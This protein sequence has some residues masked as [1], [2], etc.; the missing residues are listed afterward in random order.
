MKKIKL[1][2]MEEIPGDVQIAD[3]GVIKYMMDFGY[4]A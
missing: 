2:I 1:F 4:T 3:V